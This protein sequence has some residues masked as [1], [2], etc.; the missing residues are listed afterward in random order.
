MSHFTTL[1]TKLVDGD[2]IEGALNEMKVP[3]ER[4]D[5]VIRGFLGNK[6][7]A[8]FRVPTK[9]RSY[10]I[11]LRLAGV[12]YEVV[13][14]WWGVRGFEEQVFG[15]RLEHAYAVVATKQTLAEQGYTLVSEQQERSGEVRLVLRR[16]A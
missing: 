4:G 9:A 3:F 10:D 16:Y 7:R 5:H 12:S 13:A 2:L 15:R 11:G 8:E 14:D 1:K 6:T